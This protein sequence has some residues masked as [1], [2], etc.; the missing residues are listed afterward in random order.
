MVRN[1]GHLSRPEQ[2]SASSGGGVSSDQGRT[3]VG[4]H[5]VRGTTTAECSR[6]L[7]E[8][9]VKAPIPKRVLSSP[10]V[11]L[12][13]R[14][15]GTNMAAGGGQAEPDRLD[16]AK[17]TAY[18]KILDIDNDILVPQFI[19]RWMGELKVALGSRY[20]MEVLDEPDPTLPVLGL[21]F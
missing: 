10:W 12:G 11:R 3:L 17:L 5:P 9:G 2:V 19:D 8:C 14:L 6:E 4:M 20:L 16:P 21:R 7:R 13:L 15:G 18:P 1:V